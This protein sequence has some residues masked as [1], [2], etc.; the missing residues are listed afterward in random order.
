VVVDA[1]FLDADRRGP[2]L[3]LARELG[4]PLVVVE[5]QVTRETAQR[6]ILARRTDPTE[7]SEADWDVFLAL[8][9][10]WKEPTDLP[11]GSRVVLAEDCSWPDACLEVLDAL[12]RRASGIVP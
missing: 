3:A 10:R 1:S 8:E 7:P 9:R 2:F 11:P 5:P 12:V 6:R 4:A